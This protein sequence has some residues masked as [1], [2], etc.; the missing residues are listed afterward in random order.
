MRLNLRF[1]SGRAAVFVVGIALLAGAACGAW[2]FWGEPNL[3]CITRESVSAGAWAG[4]QK[5][6]RIAVAGDFHFAP[7]E[8][9]RA[10]KIVDAILAG[11]PD[12]V[13]LLGD[14]VN[15]HRMETSMSPKQI[16]AHFKRLAERVPVFAV[17]GNHD[18]YIG[19]RLVADA[20]SEVGITVFTEKAT[21]KSVLPNGTQIVFGGTTDAH[22]FYPVFDADDVPKNPTGGRA[23]FVL[24]SHSPDVL[25]FLN[26]SA[27]LTLCGHTHGGQICLPGGIPVFSSCRIV[28]RRFSAGMQTVPATGKAVFITR[29]LGT[30]VVPLRFCCPPE[31]AFIELCPPAELPGNFL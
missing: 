26:A 13:C 6:V 30:S 7:G 4:T 8:D 3:I 20:L 16:A 22:S 10:K 25:P 28:G 21:Q 27:D 14:Y 9:A 11:A 29:G 12:V 19:R 2:A 23:P 1:L 18:A 24:L 15:G 31:I 17:L 5:R